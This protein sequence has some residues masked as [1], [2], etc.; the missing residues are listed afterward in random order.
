MGDWVVHLSLFPDCPETPHPVSPSCRA[1]DLAR[2]CYLIVEQH[3][4][5]GVS[6]DEA[7]RVSI[8]TGYSPTHA[9][10][11]E[12]RWRDAAGNLIVRANNGFPA[13]GDAKEAAEELATDEFLTSLPVQI[14]T[15]I[16]KI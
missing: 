7:P 2:T 16:P 12:A 11:Y 5:L 8:K 6:I 15:F 13:R 10:W 9:W 1:P 3:Q 4:E 14:Y